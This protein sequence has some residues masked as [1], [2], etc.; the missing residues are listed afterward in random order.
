MEL[1]QL[2]EHISQIDG[3]ITQKL[4]ERFSI[5]RKIGAIKK[6]HMLSVDDIAREEE[7]KKL[8]ETYA[9]DHGISDKFITSLFKL[10]ITESKRIQS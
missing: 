7:L 3:E 9:R 5:A 2:R 8:H 6:K 4:A 10:I 1:E